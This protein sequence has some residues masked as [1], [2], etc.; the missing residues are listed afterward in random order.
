MIASHKKELRDL[1][2]DCIGSGDLNGKDFFSEQLKLYKNIE[3]HTQEGFEDKI[4]NY[5]A[6]AESTGKIIELLE[7]PKL[8]Y[9]A[10]T[11]DN[12]PLNLS[13]LDIDFTMNVTAVEKEFPGSEKLSYMCDVKLCGDIPNDYWSKVKIIDGIKPLNLE[14]MSIDKLKGRIMCRNVDILSKA[15]KETRKFTVT[16]DSTIFDNQV[17]AGTE[18]DKG[19]SDSDKNPDED[20]GSKSQIVKIAEMLRKDE[21]ACT[22]LISNKTSFLHLNVGKS[23]RVRVI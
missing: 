14:K 11:I 23:V 21:K 17:N 6:L 10:N 22:L 16:L 18:I 7:N 3:N 19:T 1:S 12:N 15:S 8:L 2:G 5:L 9:K 4:N 13:K 20:P